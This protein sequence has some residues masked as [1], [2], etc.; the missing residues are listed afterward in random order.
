MR[1]GCC[2]V[3]VAAGA[4]ENDADPPPP[5]RPGPETV[6]P[7]GDATLVTALLETLALEDWIQCV[8]GRKKKTKS[9]G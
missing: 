2:F 7:I 3:V 9:A 1:C 5:A 4:V 6:T 8:D